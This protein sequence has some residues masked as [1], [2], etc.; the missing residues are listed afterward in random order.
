MKARDK[1]ILDIHEKEKAAYE[2]KIERYKRANNDT[3]KELF[4]VQ[5]RGNRL[6]R[7]LGFNDVYEAQVM[8]DTSDR[9]TPYA[10]CLERI[11]GL[12]AELVAA[13]NRAEELQLVLE[14]TQREQDNLH[15][16]LDEAKNEANGHRADAARHKG[17]SEKLEAEMK[18]LQ[19]RYDALADVKERAAARYKLDYAKWR[20]FRDW[21]FNEEVEYAKDRTE[22]GFSEEEKRRRYKASLM[23]KKKMMLEL[24]PDL[25]KGPIQ[26]SRPPPLGGITN[27]YDKENVATPQRSVTTPLPSSTVVAS[28]STSKKT[29]TPTPRNRLFDSAAQADV[30]SSS[31]TLFNESTRTPLQFRPIIPTKGSPKVKQEKSPTPPIRTPKKHHTSLPGSSDTE[32]DSQAVGHFPAPIF[33]PGSSPATSPAPMASSQTEADSQSQFFPFL[34]P[35]PCPKPMPKFATPRDTPMR[36]A[37]DL[38]GDRHIVS[39]D[40]ESL[41]PTKIRRLNDENIDKDDTPKPKTKDKE[42]PLTS[43]G[44]GKDVSAPTSTPL[45]AVRLAGQKGLADYSA[46]K[47]RGRYGKTTSSAENKTINAQFE[48]D[49]ARNG[50]L[51]F[52]YDE[53]VRAKDDRKRMDAGDCECCRDYYEAVGPLPARL[54]APLWRSPPATPT[55]PCERHQHISA[56]ASTSKAKASKDVRQVEINSHRQAIS[57]HRHHWERGKTPPGYWNIGFP[58]TQEAEDINERAR[59]MHEQK[60]EEIQRAAEKEGGK[61]RRRS[62]L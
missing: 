48:I 59:E 57:R 34:E 9:E 30:P 2:L 39:R 29:S 60:R 42:P 6:A 51:D 35:T 40:E 56:S 46:F 37:F 38:T 62:G 19:E 18:L 53:V 41:Q 3:L 50:G 8:I 25:G 22:K 4:D 20:K 58:D 10:L 16:L 17:S 15:T 26:A 1:A 31:P 28:S 27:L 47:G 14:T 36:P 61:Y 33:Q 13:R 12:E 44:K 55:K 52:Q 7:S 5:Q 49:P 21:M 32:E 54:K 11:E 24:G 45:T 23:R 43:K